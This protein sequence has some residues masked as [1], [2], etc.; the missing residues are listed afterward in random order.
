M[1]C[2]WVFA[3]VSTS[4]MFSSI[5]MVG[6]GDSQWRGMTNEIGRILIV[7]LVT[8]IDLIIVFSDWEFPTFSDAGSSDQ[9]A[10][11]IA[12]SFVSDIK[13]NCL[14]SCFRACAKI[15]CVKWL[16][17]AEYF[18]FTVTGKWLNYGPLFVILGFDLNMLK[19][20][21]LYEPVGYGQYTD[22]HDNVWTI[23]DEDY[24][25]LYYED[26]IVTNDTM[27]SWGVRQGMYGDVQISK[28]SNV[29]LPIKCIAALPAIIALVSFIV[30]IAFGNKMYV[31]QG[32]RW[33]TRQSIFKLSQKRA[34]LRKHRP[35]MA[36][37]RVSHDDDA[38]H[39]DDE[40]EYSKHTNHSVVSRQSDLDTDKSESK[41]PRALSS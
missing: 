23:M 28:W 38:A 10:I 29:A 7:D 40:D 17:D 24:L 1:I 14:E 37:L 41:K 15:S 9:P 18:N 34:T 20:Q 21:V 22:P 32:D 2:V 31:Q 12:G 33:Y 25:A 27:I 16:I 26:G 11:L 19:N 36:K 35:S 3:I 30:I 4:A 39:D 6:D 8:I 13:C 5:I